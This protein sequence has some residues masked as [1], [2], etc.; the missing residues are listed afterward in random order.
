MVHRP[1]TEQIV[2]ADKNNDN[3]S[4]FAAN[5]NL[6]KTAGEDLQ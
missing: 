2:E 3:N 5:N 4:H 1:K 6:S